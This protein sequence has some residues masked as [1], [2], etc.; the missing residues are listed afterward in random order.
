MKWLLITTIGKNPGDD[1]IRIGIQNIIH[2]VDP[3]RQYIL[4]DKEIPSTYQAPVKFDKCIWCGMPVFWSHEENRNNIIDWW[5]NLMLSWPS[6]IKNNFLL[7]GAGSCFA[8]GR[9]YEKIRYMEELIKSAEDVLNRSY[10]ITARDEVVPRITG[11]PI[12][13]M[14]CPSIF[15]IVDYRKS[16]ELKFANIMPHGGHFGFLNPEEV[17]IWDEKKYRISNILQQ[18]G[19]IY[20]AHNIEEIRFAQ[21][22]GWRKII[23]YNGDPYGL[24][25]YY[26]RCGKYFGNRIHGAIIA[27]GNG[28][29]AWSVGYDSRQEAVR[30]S[31]A[32][33]S[34]PSELNID[35][36]ADWASCDIKAEPF[37][38]KSNFEKQ[39]EIVRKF[40]LAADT[41]DIVSPRKGES[42]KYNLHDKSGEVPVRKA[43]RV[44]VAKEHVRNGIKVDTESSFGAKLKELFARITPQKVIETG[45]YL[46]TGTTTII[47]QALKSLKLQRQSVFYTIEVN[48]AFYSQA[49]RH[50]Q[51]NNLKA[52]CLNGLSV[53]RSL[54]PTIEDIRKSTV[55]NIEYDDIFI[56]HEPEVRAQLYYDE[57]NFTNV[58]DD[59]LGRCLK[60]FEYKPDF[61][62]LDSAGHLGNIEFN[63]L[64]ERLRGPCYIALDDIYHIKHH[65]SFQQIQGDPRFEVITA[66]KEKFGFCIAKFTPNQTAKNEKISKLK[67]PDAQPAD[68][69]DALAYK[70]SRKVLIVRPDSIGDFVIFSGVLQ[71]FRQ[72]YS[73]AHISLLV[74]KHI[75]ELASSCPYIDEVI[76]FDRTLAESDWSYLHTLTKQLQEKDFDVAINPVYSRTD[77]DDSIVLNTN[78]KEKIAFIGDDTNMDIGKKLLHDTYY[79]RLVPATDGMLIETK[80]NEE[81]ARGLGA[82][83]DTPCMPTVWVTGD[84][85]TYA[86]NL[87]A[88]L[89]VKEPILVC[90]YAQTK[91][92]QWPIHKWARLLSRYNDY[93]ILICGTKDDK[94]QA[95]LLTCLTGHRHIHN[96]CGR[97]NLRQ[98]AALLARSRLCISSESGSAHIAAAMDCPQVVI[99]GGGHFGRFM[100]YS[101]TTNLV[102]LP[103]NCYNC[104]WRCP[105][106]YWETYCISQISVKTV[107]QAV[108]EVLVKPYP[109]DGQPRCFKNESIKCLFDSTVP[110]GSDAS[111][112]HFADDIFTVGSRKKTA[113]RGNID[114]GETDIKISATAGKGNPDAALMDNKQGKYLV[115]AIVSTYNSE[116]FIAR[117]LQDLENQTIADKLEIIVVNSGSQQNEESVVRAFQQKYGNI[118]YIRTENRETIYQAWNRAIRMASGKYITNANTDDTH[119]TTALEILARALEE[120]PDAVLAYADQGRIDT[121]SGEV[122]GQFIAGEFSRYR[123]LADW[124]YISSHPMWRKKVHE[125]FGYFDET[126]VTA[127]DWEFWLRISQKYDFVYVNETLGNRLWTPDCLSRRE[128]EQ[129]QGLAIIEAELIRKCYHYAL[130]TNLVIDYRGISANPLFST[131]PEVNLWKQKSQAKLN[132]VPYH[133]EGN[134]ENIND[135][136]K[137][138]APRLSIVI[139][140]Y[141]DLSTLKANL[142]SLNEQTT[143]DFEVIVVNSGQ[144]IPKP[145]QISRQL[146]YGFCCIELKQNLGPSLA[147]NIGIRR[148]RGE[149]VAFLDDHTIA[150]KDFVRNILTYFDHLQIC[151]LRGKILPSDGANTRY[152]PPD[153]DLGQE[154]IWSAC[155]WGTNCAFRKD[156]LE[157]IG[158]FNENLFSYEMQE[159]SYRI[160]KANNEKID[161]ILYFPDV[162]VYHSAPQGDLPDYVNQLQRRIAK[163]IAGYKSPEI[164]SYLELARIQYP[165]KQ[166]QLQK[167]YRRLLSAVLL[168]HKRYPRDAVNWAE[169]AAALNPDGIECRFVLGSLHLLLERY[170]KARII[171]ETI[172]GSLE[173]AMT[174]DEAKFLSADLNH[175]PDIAFYFTS[176]CTKLAQCYIKQ[177]KLDKVRQIYTTLLNNPNLTIP[178]QQKA[179][180]LA[181]LNKIDKKRHTAVIHEKHTNLASPYRP[182]RGHLVSAIVSTYNAEQ[183]IRGCLQD[184]EN[185][186]IADRL[187]IIVV[188]SGSSQNEEAIVKEFQQKYT[189]IKYIKTK[190]RETIYA[191]WNRAIKIAQGMFITNANTDDRHR[192]DALQIMA[193]ALL[194]NPDIALVYADQIQTDTPNDTFDHLHQAK[195]LRRPD[196]SRERLLLGCCVG[197]QPMWRKSLHDEFGYFDQTLTC[198]GDWDFWLR[199][200]NKYEFKHIPEFLGLYYHNK[201]GIEHSRKI[202]NL[203]ERYKVGKKH[204]TPYISVIGLYQCENNPLVSIIMPAYNA[205]ACIASAIE[206]VLIQNYRNFELIIVDDGSTD[207]TRDMVAG[208]EDQKIK[209]FYQENAGPAAARNLALKKANGAFIVN[210]DADDMIT[211]DFI[212]RHLQEFEKHPE[213]DL[214][215]C[216]DLLID[217]NDKPIR[218]IT[219]PEYSD[220]K[221]LIRDLFRSGFPVVPFRTCI[222]KEV[223]DKIGLFDEQLLVAE[224]YDMMRRFVKNDLKMH[225]L[226]DA[227]YLRRMT[228]GSLSS[229]LAH[230]D[231][232]K[233]QSHFNVIQRF[234]DTFTYEQLFPEVEWDKIEP[235][236]RPLYARSL[237]AVTC[238]AI[239]QAYAESNSPVCARTAFDHAYLELFECLKAEPN[240]QLFQNLLNKSELLR[241]R[242]TKTEQQAVC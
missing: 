225:H 67:D 215:Y 35:E 80:R 158:G 216:D 155:E 82:P 168:L 138:S 218:A 219:R 146:N 42:I 70:E 49:K 139:I 46:G 72:L 14:I 214:I 159:L 25:T 134:I 178:P 73:N 190:Q 90:P 8:W 116:N 233:A 238:L 76:S 78:A 199:I 161:G 103:M 52:I 57:T 11:K 197:S 53:P 147:R 102:Y 84:D 47:A 203:Y 19:F 224:D 58:E 170:D 127:G 133:P 232:R 157:R 130:E 126:F 95:D 56:D 48:P 150:E 122:T 32:R 207:N 94:N 106:C 112:E 65:R 30:L 242:F 110:Q 23:P 136:R 40:R 186:T 3:E 98:L 185:Q 135:Y 125:Q 10:Y 234:V 165:Y 81:F 2:E 31:G 182:P 184:L 38:M 175:S 137:A 204:G 87:L 143:A 140:S 166:K 105:Y 27:R 107:D 63:Y 45:T 236:K 124:C 85:K 36:I 228:P 21:E 164:E 92:R 22:C 88:E 145:D 91:A 141:A 61:V 149:Y 89:E 17:N 5:N 62:L 208:F 241:A 16:H 169:K 221:S 83:V 193:N 128:L 26:G 201:D 118:K 123:M 111:P 69:L 171:L 132:A 43:N 29:D 172:L 202:H 239:G 13:Y 54:L 179:D 109:S 120:N 71:Y 119:R 183:F 156:I 77:L 66:S 79:D 154:I 142:A 101:P 64:I 114:G 60:A 163:R 33:V 121:A 7:L 34:K 180:I 181:V 99:I 104:N 210:L 235:R 206:S 9:E 188:N 177:G 231:A 15:S 226:K 37:D 68:K 176:T 55:T 148:A 113:S 227:L 205:D 212:A 196:Y 194:A 198:A 151:G 174:G 12:P 200:S 223:F 129:E 96:I 50:I 162:I 152:I 195:K 51:V 28:A 24:L 108:Q 230:Y 189:N 173:A 93:P 39:V 187:E 131:W 1:W 4:L 100:P 217:E 153:L 74:Q 192:K 222:R 44:T 229:N 213:V 117:C 167:D 18:N 75:A 20:V 59:L 211:P 6:Q 209:Y 237:A 41:S 240:N 86:D 191:A 115:T 144:I 220:R 97:T 160:Y